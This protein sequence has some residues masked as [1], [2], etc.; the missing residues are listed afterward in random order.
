MDEREYITELR[1]LLS[2][3]IKQDDI[4][5]ALEILSQIAFAENLHSSRRSLLSFLFKWS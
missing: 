2:L 5:L 4:R 3:A 1:N